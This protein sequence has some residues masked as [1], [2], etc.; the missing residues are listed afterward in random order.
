MGYKVKA[1]MGKAKKRAILN[2]KQ[3]EE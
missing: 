3:L 2:K 1:R